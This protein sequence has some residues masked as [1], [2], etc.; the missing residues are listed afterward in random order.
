MV[1][2]HP[3]GEGDQI[4]QLAQRDQ[5]DSSAAVLMSDSL[6]EKNDYMENNNSLDRL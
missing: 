1:G 2:I 4:V 6:I 3:V 5:G